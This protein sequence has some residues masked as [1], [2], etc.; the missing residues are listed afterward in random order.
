MERVLFQEIA[1]P[2][3]SSRT[4]QVGSQ[5]RRVL[6]HPVPLWYQLCAC[7]PSLSTYE[8]REARRNV[9][10]R[11]QPRSISSLRALPKEIQRGT[12]QPFILIMQVATLAYF[13]KLGFWMWG[14]G[15]RSFG[16]PLRCLSVPGLA[17]DYFVASMT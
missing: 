12:V 11:D 2:C 17:F 16:A 3:R 14:Q 6:R 1:T 5:G 15:G 13:S 7:P 4:P 9:G 10:R 8:P